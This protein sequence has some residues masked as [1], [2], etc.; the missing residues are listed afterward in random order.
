MYGISIY[1]SRTALL[2]RF[3]VSDTQTHTLPFALTLAHTERERE[4]E[5]QYLFH[6]FIVSVG[7]FYLE[8]A[9]FFDRLFIMSNAFIRI[10]RE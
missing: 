10:W 7:G 5:R 2:L 3:S 9:L 6:T 4:R 1:V 8:N